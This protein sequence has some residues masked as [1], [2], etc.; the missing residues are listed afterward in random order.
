MTEQQFEVIEGEACPGCG[1]PVL[2]IYTVTPFAC[3]TH[4]ERIV[5]KRAR[6]QV[7]RYAGELRAA[8][9]SLL[10]ATDA[11]FCQGEVYN[12]GMDEQ[13]DCGFCAY[14]KAREALGRLKPKPSTC[15]CRD[16]PEAAS[17]GLHHQTECPNY[18]PDP[19][20]TIKACA[21]EVEDCPSCER[22]ANGVHEETLGPTW[23]GR[24][25]CKQPQ[26]GHEHRFCR[27]HTH[28]ERYWPSACTCTGLCV[29]SWREDGFGRI[30]PDPECQA[31]ITGDRRGPN[32]TVGCTQAIA[33]DNTIREALE[34]LQMGEIDDAI[35][36]LE[37]RNKDTGSE[38]Y[39][40]QVDT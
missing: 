8:L 38:P 31:P 36:I 10:D 19:E 35:R 23:C 12:E 7:C 21:I 18:G 32:H 24:S 4:N 3:G 13:L 20:G 27:F 2:A 11:E 29:C 34:L 22:R 15:W 6:T 17:V 28:D 40:D 5:G 16:A 30:C 25:G 33:P 39:T 26:D 9:G 1:A 14:R 37:G